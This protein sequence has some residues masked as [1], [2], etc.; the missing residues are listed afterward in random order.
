VANWRTTV[1]LC[2]TKPFP[3]RLGRRWIGVHSNDEASLTEQL[4]H[5]RRRIGARPAAHGTPKHHSRLSPR[6]FTSTPGSADAKA[7]VIPSR[8]RR[9]GPRQW[10]SVLFAALRK[11]PLT[12]DKPIPKRALLSPNTCQQRV[13]KSACTALW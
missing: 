10:E 6:G 2:Q 3:A 12:E 1:V 8:H 4:Q 5:V 13:V 11:G 9:A 7:A